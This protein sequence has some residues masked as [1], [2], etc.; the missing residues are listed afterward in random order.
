MYSSSCH[1]VSNHFTKTALTLRCLFIPTS[2][3][4]PNRGKGNVPGA[5]LWA[6][7]PGRAPPPASTTTPSLGCCCHRAVLRAGTPSWEGRRGRHRTWSQLVLPRGGLGARWAA[8]AGWRR[9][10]TKGACHSKHKHH[11]A[12]MR[13]FRERDPHR[14]TAASS[15]CKDA[16]KNMREPKRVKGSTVPPPTRV[17]AGRWEPEGH[18]HVSDGLVVSLCN[19]SFWQTAANAGVWARSVMQVPRVA[20]TDDWCQPS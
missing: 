17:T 18:G 7:L 10:G 12:A 13:I 2:S 5:N 16:C 8:G 9:E 4:A 14:V 15:E 1:V 6:L 3:R 11:G 20:K 19:F